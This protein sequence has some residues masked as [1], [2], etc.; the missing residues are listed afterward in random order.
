MARQPSAAWKSIHAL[1]ISLDFDT[2][3]IYKKAKT[4]L[5][6]YQDSSWRISSSYNPAVQSA[7]DAAWL[8]PDRSFLEYLIDFSDTTT[9]E[10]FKSTIRSFSDAYLL[11]EIFNSSFLKVKSYPRHGRLYY[12]ILSKCFLSD[13]N[14]SEAD[15]LLLLSMERSL[16]Y[17]RKKEAIILFGCVLWGIELPKLKQASYSSDT[18]GHSFFA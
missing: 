10:Q 2:T 4:L 7:L 1:C 11:T 14:L 8:N 3:T 16:F 13:F 5:T 18:I 6:S 17:A 9:T 12:D 15:L